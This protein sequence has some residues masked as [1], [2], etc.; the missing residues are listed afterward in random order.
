MIVFFLISVILWC[1]VIYWC[2][3]LTCM[4]NR[5]FF[6]S[7]P[8]NTTELTSREANFFFPWHAAAFA[9]RTIFDTYISVQQ[10]R[11]VGV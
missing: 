11:R 4:Y 7:Q 3:H 8:V 1:L 5:Q 6:L 2:S 10:Q 9:Y